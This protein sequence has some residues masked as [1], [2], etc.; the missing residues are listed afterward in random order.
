MPEDW[1]ARFEGRLRPGTFVHPKSA[2]GNGGAGA[3]R[4][5]EHRFPWPNFSAPHPDSAEGRHFGWQLEQARE[6]Q[7]ERHELGEQIEKLVKTV[8]EQCEDLR[9]ALPEAA[10]LAMYDNQVRELKTAYGTGQ[11]ADVPGLHTLLQMLQIAIEFVDSGSGRSPQARLGSE[12]A[13]GRA[14]VVWKLGTAAEKNELLAEIRNLAE[15]VFEAARRSLL[16]EW[17]QAARDTEQRLLIERWKRLLYREG[18]SSAT[19]DED[20]A[21]PPTKSPKAPVKT[22]IEIE[23]LEEESGRPVAGAEYRIKL[24]DGTVRG[25]TLDSKGRARYDDIDPGQCEVWFPEI[26]AKEWHAA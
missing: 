1:R 17:S 12:S 23:L 7:Q 4:Y 14:Y 20:Q 3:F 18:G 5:A 22:W 13:V 26:D 25:G 19:E 9:S 15:Q 6:Q 2:D 16:E 8:V 24:P 21:P 11:G 10:L